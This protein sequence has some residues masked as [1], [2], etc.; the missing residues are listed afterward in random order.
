MHGLQ[1]HEDAGD[2][3]HKMKDSFEGILL[4]HWGHLADQVLEAQSLFTDHHTGTETLVA[5]FAEGNFQL[6]RGLQLG[7]N[8]IQNALFMHVLDGTST[9]TDRN[10]SFGGFKTNPASDVLHLLALAVCLGGRWVLSIDFFGETVLRSLQHWLF[11]II[12][13]QLLVI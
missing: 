8:P 11:I 10:E 6:A 3:H 2:E 4:A 5:D 12:F 13:K 9:A 1:D 7:S